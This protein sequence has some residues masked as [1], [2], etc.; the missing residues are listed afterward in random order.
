M[1]GRAIDEVKGMNPETAANGITLLI[2]EDEV[3]PA[4]ALKDELEEAGYDRDLSAGP[5][6]GRRG[7]CAPRRA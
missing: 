7:V 2:V 1:N 5:P 4:M 6:E 3:L